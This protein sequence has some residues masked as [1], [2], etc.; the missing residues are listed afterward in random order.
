M[1]EHFEQN[2]NY[3]NLTKITNKHKHNLLTTFSVLNHVNNN[4]IN[5]QN[6]WSHLFQTI[7]TWKNMIMFQNISEKKSCRPIHL[8]VVVNK[9]T[10]NFKLFCCHS[11][12]QGCLKR[13]PCCLTLATFAPIAFMAFKVHVLMLSIKNTSNPKCTHG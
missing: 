6:L 7:T 12:I 8:C 11:L 9:K 1:G 4:V 3:T 2:P 13:L 5:V 10:L